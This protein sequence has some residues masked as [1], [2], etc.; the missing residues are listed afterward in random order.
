MGE[1]KSKTTLEKSDMLKVLVAENVPLISGALTALI[2][3]EPDMKVVAEA[4]HDDEILEIAL[5][6]RPDVAVIDI[7][8]PGHDRLPAV[9]QLHDQLPTCRSLVL[10]TLGHPGTN[11]AVLAPGVS[12]FIL[13]NAPAG[14]LAKTIRNV[15]AGRRVV[16]PELAAATWEYDGMPLSKREYA[17]LRLAGNGAEPAEIAANLDLSVGTVRNYLTAIVAKLHAR[18]RVDAVRKA[19][20]AGWLP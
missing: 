12:G 1:A 15:A 6:H 13:K 4:G 2:E 16:G 10:M 9:A 11:R 17:V 20:N 19:Y 18:N 3:S 8:W 14:Q 7:D 5:L